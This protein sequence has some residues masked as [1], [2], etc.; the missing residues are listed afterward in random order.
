MK[1]PPRKGRPARWWKTCLGITGGLV[2]VL[3]ITAVVVYLRATH[4]P[5]EKEAFGDL[6]TPAEVDAARSRLEYAA[7]QAA[8]IAGQGGVEVRV[9]ASDVNLLVRAE[10]FHY[11]QVYGGEA[12]VLR[13]P[14][15]PQVYDARL[16]LAPPHIN[17]SGVLISGERRLW[18]RAVMEPRVAKQGELELALI[19]ARVGEIGV[20]KFLLKRVGTALG[21][22]LSFAVQERGLVLKDARVQAGE[23]I[24]TV[25]RG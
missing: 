16:S 6:P 5:E 19:G 7:G 17:F 3:A 23:L 22:R 2:A 13:G 1:P 9:S 25:A 18:L 11:R 12:Q 24:L 20:P 15:R 14:D 10:T 21:G 8:L 4:T